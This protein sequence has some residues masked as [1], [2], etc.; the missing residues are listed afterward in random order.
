V[1]LPGRAQKADKVAVAAPD[2]PPLN[3]VEQVP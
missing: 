2:A 3:M 1:R